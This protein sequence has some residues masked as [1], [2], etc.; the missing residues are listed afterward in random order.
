MSV[1][2]EDIA[3]I[4]GECGGD[5]A[6]V[7]DRLQLP[8]EELLKK[9]SDSNVVGSAPRV[10]TPPADLGREPL[11]KYVVAVRHSEEAYWS[12]EDLEK[13]E[14][15]RAKYCA[16]THEISQGKD[17]GWFVLYCTPRTIRTK[18]RKWYVDEI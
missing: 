14:K 6:K 18:P 10:R 1:T 5:L 7:A 3:A 11:R 8:Y 9:L 2:S 4:Y 12:P 15:A 17:R 13:I 16:G